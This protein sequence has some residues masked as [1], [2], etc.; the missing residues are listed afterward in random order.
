MSRRKSRLLTKRDIQAA[1]GAIAKYLNVLL[2]GKEQIPFRPGTS[3]YHA[4][5][6]HL[7]KRQDAQKLDNLWFLCL[8][9]VTKDENEYRNLLEET[10][11]FLKS[12]GEAVEKFEMKKR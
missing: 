12:K 8:I 2:E 6:S 4:Y 9:C 7:T 5:S 1:I 11:L 10:R 3:C